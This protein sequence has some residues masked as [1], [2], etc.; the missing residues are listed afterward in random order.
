VK[1]Y[2]F[3]EE[4]TNSRREREFGAEELDETFEFFV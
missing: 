4:D 1:G 2:N 3:T